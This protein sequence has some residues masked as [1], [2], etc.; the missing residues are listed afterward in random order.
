MSSRQ[1]ES[2]LSEG[3]TEFIRLPYNKPDSPLTYPRHPTEIEFTLAPSCTTTID[4]LTG[5]LASIDPGVAAV[6]SSSV[7]NQFDSPLQDLV[8]GEQI[9]RNQLMDDSIA[10]SEGEQEF[11]FQDGP[12]IQPTGSFIIFR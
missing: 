11:G 1:V 3:L 6:T 9:A 10:D 12:Q 2:V 8:I 7:T 4:C 5:N